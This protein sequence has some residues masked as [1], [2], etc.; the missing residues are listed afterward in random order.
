M[1]TDFLK[2]ELWGRRLACS[3]MWK[4]Y[5]VT[6]I[7]LR[8][9]FFLGFRTKITKNVGKNDIF[10]T[11]G[12][13]ALILFYSLQM[14]WHHLP[15][16]IADAEDDDRKTD[17]S[18]NRLTWFYENAAV[19]FCNCGLFEFSLRKIETSFA[20]QLKQGNWWIKQKEGCRLFEEQLRDERGNGSCVNLLQMYI[21]NEC[22]EHRSNEYYK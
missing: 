18:S 8:N 10:V 2:I 19:I 11:C 9:T 15:P 14:L 13:K 20:P 22:G 21:Q 6:L 17:L 12:R 5:I 16:N 3:R 4:T 7:E 1:L